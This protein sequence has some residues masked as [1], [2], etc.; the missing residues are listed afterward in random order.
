[1]FPILV[2]WTVVKSSINGSKSWEAQGFSM[3]LLDAPNFKEIQELDPNF[4]AV[5]FEDF[6]FELYARAQHARTDLDAMARLSPYLKSRVRTSLRLRSGRT[7]SHVDGV[8]IGA[9]SVAKARATTNFQFIQVDFEANYTETMP[10]DKRVGFYSVERW[11]FRRAATTK[12]RPIAAIRAFN[13]PSCGAPA[14]DDH[15]AECSHCG[16]SN[17]AGDFDWQCTRVTVHREEQRPPALTEYAPEVTPQETI[18][19]D[20]AERSFKKL[21]DHHHDGV[22]KIFNARVHKVYTQLN[23]AWS[24]LQWDDARPFLSD[25][26]WL[27]WRYWIHAYSEQGLRNEMRDANLERFTVVKVNRDPYFDAVTVRIYASAIDVTVDKRSGSI[28]GGDK[29]NARAYSEY[30]TFIRPTGKEGSD[31]ENECP[32]CGATLDVE[33]AGRCG[34]C[35]VKV[36]RGGFDWVLSTVAQD[37]AYR[38]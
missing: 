37:E 14:E 27:S 20:D 36:Q 15:E 26:L 38:G 7:P 9:I 10:D 8:V 31:A 25:R 12:S 35:K 19:E 18:A 16:Q 11:T 2:G 33:M 29:R 3:P 30:W 32:N 13:C 17:D 22:T 4:S 5:L 34:A 23:Q 6:A 1:M 24:T 21:I 28:R